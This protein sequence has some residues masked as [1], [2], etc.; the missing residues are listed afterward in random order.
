MNPPEPFE[1]AQRDAS[2]VRCTACGETMQA[3]VID[4]HHCDGAERT[5]TTAGGPQ[6]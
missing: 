3:V 4:L 2:R 5:A 6:R 1:W